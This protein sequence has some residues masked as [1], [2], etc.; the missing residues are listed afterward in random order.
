MSDK[1]KINLSEKLE[2]YLDV[3]DNDFY[4]FDFGR[5]FSKI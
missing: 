4:L 2:K 5:F 3:F 1:R